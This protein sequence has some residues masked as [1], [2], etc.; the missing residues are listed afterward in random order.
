MLNSEFPNQLKIKAIFLSLKKNFDHRYL[1]ILLSLFIYTLSFNQSAFSQVEEKDPVQLFNQGQDA[2]EKGDYTTALKLYEEALSIAPEFPEAEFQRGNALQ[3]L[4]RENEAEKAFQ[5][6]IELRED[7]VLP[8]VSLGEILVRKNKYSAAE[9]IL[10]KAIKLDDKNSQAYLALT[11]MRLKTKSTSETLKNLLETLQSFSNPDAAILTARG[12]IERNL[13]NMPAAKTNFER[14]FSIDKKNSFLLAEMIEISLAEKNYENAVA[15]AQTLVKFYPNS[16][17]G[18]LLLTR[19]YAESGNTNEALKI[20]ETLDQQNSEVANLRG[21]ILAAGTKDIGLLEKQLETDPKNPVILGRLCSLTR[22]NPSKALIYCQRAVEVEPNNIEHAVGFGAAL[23]QAKQFENA[24][25]LLKK[26][27]PYEPENF[28]IHSN[29]ASAFF[30]LKR[31]SEAK[32][33]FQ[34]LIEKK[35]DLAVAYY[36]LAIA[37]DNLAEY[38][39]ALTNYQKFLQ[40]ADTKQNSLEIDKV[41]FRVPVLQKQIKQGAGSKKGKNDE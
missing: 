3:S 37:H 20:I 13:G 1:L 6:A 11:E 15:T 39:E 21:Q 18:K 38:N 31:F 22:T 10:T 19:V 9:E 25:N 2:H 17:S 27:I 24:V 35:P 16:L 7:W 34:W 32:I 41:N 23:V 8:M 33:E 30:E 26:L 36:F 14:A 29:L 12:A 40:I 28:A 5:K 4:G